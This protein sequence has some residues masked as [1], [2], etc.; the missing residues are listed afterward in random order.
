MFPKIKFFCLLALVAVFFFTLPTAEACTG[1]MFSVEPLPGAPDGLYAFQARTMEFGPDVTGWQIISVPKGYIYKSCKYGI[2]GS[3]VFGFN[4]T[5]KYQH[6]GMSPSRPDIPILDE[7]A[8]GINEKGLAC[9]AFYH[10]GYEEY[11][12]NPT[13]GKAIADTDFVSWVLSNF[14]TVK[15]VRDA[16]EQNTVD[17]A[18]FTLTIKGKLMCTS[19]TCPQLH[20]AVTDESGAAIVIEFKK[21]KSKIFE[22]AGVITNDPTYDWHTTN[23]QNYI[24]LQALTRDSAVFSGK[25]YNKL[26]NGTGAIGLPGDFTPPS[27]FVRAMF[28]LSTSLPRTGIGPDEAIA[29]AF[30][31]LNQFDIPVGSVIADSP[32]GT[33]Q[34]IQD[35]TMW[36]SLCDLKRK[37]YYFHCQK[38]RTLRMIELDKQPKNALSI[39]QLPQQETIVNMSDA[40]IPVTNKP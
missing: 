7:V 35:S 28:F 18:Q 34:Q 14:A 19:K 9:G 40:F 32:A 12:T 20:Y 29:D 16:M 15:E 22:S 24:G 5:A 27:R 1:L 10:M 31:I 39:Q 17:V 13:T 38:D 3:G 2:C 25:T 33:G 8:D 11:N 21:G 37:R 26:G 4:W 6:V 30:R 23:V 36:T